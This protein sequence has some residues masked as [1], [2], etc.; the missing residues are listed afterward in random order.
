MDEKRICSNTTHKYKVIVHKTHFMF[1]QQRHMPQ[2]WFLIIL[3]E[4]VNA[5]KILL[6]LLLVLFISKN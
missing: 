1:D 5:T 6:K 4:C 3:I 2:D